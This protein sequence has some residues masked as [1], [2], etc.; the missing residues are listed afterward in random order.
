MS[1]LGCDSRRSH[2][3]CRIK[4]LLIPIGT[5]ASFLRDRTEQIYQRYLTNATMAMRCMPHCQ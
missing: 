3:F 5:F 4:S 2:T 1:T